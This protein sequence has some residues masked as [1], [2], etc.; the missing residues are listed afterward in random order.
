MQWV[1]NSIDRHEDLTSSD[2]AFRT[3]YWLLRPQF[4]QGLS[5]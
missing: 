1:Q 4:I 3:L 2:V 5:H